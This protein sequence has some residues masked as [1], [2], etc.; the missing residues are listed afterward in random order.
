MR[1]DEFASAEEQLRLLKLIMASTLK[2]LDDQRRAEI[3]QATK[4]KAAYRGRIPVKRQA[5]LTYQPQQSQRNPQAQ[6]KLPA[7][8]PNATNIEAPVRPMHQPKAV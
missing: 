4:R 2:A 3:A 8:H 6:P 5:A 1:L 7:D